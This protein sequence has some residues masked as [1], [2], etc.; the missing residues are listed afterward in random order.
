MKNVARNVRLKGER[1]SSIP[2]AL[3]EVKYLG[4][5]VDQFR[6]L[7]SVSELAAAGEGVCYVQSREGR[8]EENA[9]NMVLMTITLPR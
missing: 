8:G 3:V 7:P 9:P 4:E 5:S 6:L 1:Y 2:R